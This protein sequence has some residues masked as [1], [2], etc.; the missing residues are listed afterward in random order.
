MKKKYKF[1][2]EKFGKW[3]V[4][5]LITLLTIS[6]FL[7][8]I[9][10]ALVFPLIKIISNPEIISE[11][12]LYENLENYFINLDTSQ[13]VLLSLAGYG[14]VNFAKIVYSIFLTWFNI[15]LIFKI[16]VKLTKD[17]FKHYMYLPYM[18][19]QKTNSA[20]LVRNVQSEISIICKSLFY[21]FVTII[22]E[23]IILLTIIAFLFYLDP[24]AISVLVL[25]FLFFTVAYYGLIN[26]KIKKWGEI[27]IFQDKIKLKNLLQ[28]FAGIK[29]IKLLNKE[30]YFIRKFFKPTYM[31]ADQFRKNSI[32]LQLPRFFLE[33][34]FVI[35]ILV[36]LFYNLNK[37]I[38]LISI[39]PFLAVYVVA[40]L[41]ILPSY[42][43][44]YQNFQLIKFSIPSFH[45]VYDEFNISSQKEIL[46]NK[47]E[48]FSF[49]KNIELSNISFKYPG[50]TKTLF[51]DLNLNIRKGSCIGIM[52]PSGVGKSTLV[53][54]ILGLI[55]VDKGKIECDG[56]NIIENLSGWFSMISHIPQEVFIL[57]ETLEENIIFG[58]REKKNSKQILDE[59]I[60]SA[61][62]NAFKNQKI[63]NNS[64][65]LGDR[66]VQI[67]GG[68]R[69]RIGIARALYNQS[70]I[71]ILDEFT[72]ALDATTEKKILSLIGDLK[73]KKTIIMIS[74]NENI[75]NLCETVYKLDKG[76]LIKIKFEK[77]ENN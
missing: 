45:K 3:N 48:D 61:Q 51:N 44:I 18:F 16:Q 1:Y 74:H 34:I 36:Y 53:D 41:R 22:T 56:V 26:K 58:E 71:L 60:D 29:E 4:F 12:N 19:H 33:F 69:Q 46:S 47:S 13:L 43:K 27:R 57:D 59:V 50:T 39:L 54:I 23:I 73:N 32:V 10:I 35:L 31:V 72:N 25:F 11:Y 55:K 17:L 49:K 42:L 75:F 70:Q 6:S 37:G 66:G 9:G 67:S 14:F 24:I 77:N 38:E 20:K 65:T 2:L 8:F 64:E 62:L 15:S 30:N 63:E 21:P 52:G 7:E 68:E 76:Q 28:S 40:A 5:I